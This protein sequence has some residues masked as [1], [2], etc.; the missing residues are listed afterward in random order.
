M[1]YQKLCIYV[2]EDDKLGKR[3][4]Y[5][6]ILRFLRERGVKGATV[7]KGVFGWGPDGVVHTVRLL[8]AT[9]NL[10]LKIEVIEEEE[11]I[12]SLLPELE[13]LLHKGLIT[14]SPITKII[15]K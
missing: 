12:N 13:R 7:F 10:P 14:I 6:E 9:G 1:S 5:E 2:D 4:L 3:P 11:T 8:R 15:K